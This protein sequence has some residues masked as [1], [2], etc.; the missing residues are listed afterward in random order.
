MSTFEPS[1]LPHREHNEF[2][3]SPC[4][5]IGYFSAD[6]CLRI[7]KLSESLSAVDGGVSH[8]GVPAQDIR[9]SKIRWMNPST[10]TRWVYEKLWVAIEQV[11]RNYRFD[12]DGIREV[13]IARY[14]PGDFYD[15]HVDIGKDATSTRKLSLSVQLSDPETYRGGDLILQYHEDKEPV[16]DLGSVIVFPSYL[17]HRVNAITEG[18]RWS[19]VA[20]VHGPAFR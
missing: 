10:Q 9:S 6:E 17:S 12:L 14:G 20:W 4:N 19:L 16:R 3:D 13:Q 11:N 18:E 5:A 2:L 8:E 1:G 7:R 15:W